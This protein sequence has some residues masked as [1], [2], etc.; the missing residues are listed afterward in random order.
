[1]EN[2]HSE[3]GFDEAK[4]AT[5]ASGERSFDLNKWGVKHVFKDTVYAKV[6]DET[7]GSIK[8]GSLFIPTN[9]NAKEFMRFL[10][11]ELA[12]SDC[13]KEIVKDAIIVVPHEVFTVSTAIKKNGEKYYFL[14]ESYIM[15]VVEPQS[16]DR[17]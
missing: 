16:S 12:G 14:R 3:F 8:R 13:A 15:A 5:M 4:Y 1:M 2:D 17:E 10:K 7:D 11:V 6:I 9:Q